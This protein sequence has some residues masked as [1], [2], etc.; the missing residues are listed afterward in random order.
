M[1]RFACTCLQLPWL[2]AVVAIGL[3]VVEGRDAFLNPPVS[4]HLNVSDKF[5]RIVLRL[6]LRSMMLCSPL[7]PSILVSARSFSVMGWPAY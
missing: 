4:R 6:C 1:G 7:Q 5:R 3:L 2:F